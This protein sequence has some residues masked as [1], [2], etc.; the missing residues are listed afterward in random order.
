M[1]VNQCIPCY[2][3]FLSAKF[4]LFL[5]LR[6]K[7]WVRDLNEPWNAGSNSAKNG[8][9]IHLLSSKRQDLLSAAIVWCSCT[10]GS[11]HFLHCLFGV[12]DLR[13]LYDL[14]ASLEASDVMS[15]CFRVLGLGKLMRAR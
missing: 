15:A 9:T 6:Y 10:D 5:G 2:I 14:S 4:V 13:V 11:N 8:L 1:S 12:L 3:W 7:S